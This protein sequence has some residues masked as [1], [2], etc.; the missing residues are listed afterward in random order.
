M[1]IYTYIHI[2]IHIYICI[3]ILHICIYICIYIDIIHVLYSNST[4]FSKVSNILTRRTNWVS[5]SNS[6]GATSEAL[7]PL[8][9]GENDDVTMWCTRMHMKIDDVTMW[10]IHAY[11]HS[12]R[13]L[14]RSY[15][16]LSVVCGGGYM[17]VIWG[18]GYM[19]TF[20]NLKQLNIGE[21][22]RV[23]EGWNEH[24]GQWFVKQ[25]T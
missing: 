12:G 24:R 18:G 3:Y 13:W 6:T 8:N 25:V 21:K 10:Y 14:L 23:V 19:L 5:C 9:I 15:T 7:E 22:V 17:H 1:Y 4:T 2:Y 20:E 11:V 16:H